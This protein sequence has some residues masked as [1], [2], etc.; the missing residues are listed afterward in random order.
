MRPMTHS[1]NVTLICLLALR[2]A[3]AA[4]AQPYTGYWLSQEAVTLLADLL[5]TGH[6]RTDR[7]LEKAIDA[8]EDSLAL[9][10]WTDPNHLVAGI[11]AEVFQAERRAMRRLEDVLEDGVAD[12]EIVEEAMVFL[13]STDATL[14]EIAILGLRGAEGVADCEAGSDGDSDSD[15]RTDCDCA[16][17]RNWIAGALEQQAL[18]FTAFSAADFEASVRA[19]MVAWKETN[20]GRFELAECP[21][22]D[23]DCPCL[24]DNMPVF[25]S[26]ADGSRPLAA[27]FF[28]QDGDDTIIQIIDVPASIAEVIIVPSEDAALCEEHDRVPWP[29]GPVTRYYLTP[30]AAQGCVDILRALVVDCPCDSNPATTH[31][32]D[33]VEPP[34][35]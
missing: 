23:V 25:T 19:F 35:P 8:I 11:G 34:S 14:V 9:E 2:S 30:E 15:P 31:I 1:P 29:P 27:C 26:F 20:R 4:M 16:K 22:L 13:I 32:P 33:C 7:N 5:P 3:P 6:S 12:E 28:D 21:V 24:N 18:A 17:A 10:L